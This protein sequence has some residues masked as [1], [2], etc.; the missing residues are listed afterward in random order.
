MSGIKGCPFSRIANQNRNRPDAFLW[1]KNS[2]KSSC[3]SKRHVVKLAQ[4]VKPKLLRLF[5]GEHQPFAATRSR[6]A[7]FFCTDTF[8]SNG[9]VS[10]VP[11]FTLDAH[12]TD[13]Q[14]MDFSC[15]GGVLH[16]LVKERFRGVG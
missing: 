1:I 14:P 16:W 8:C 9:R 11:R 2:L 7:E 15:F 6:G 10:R 4:V 5:W 12:S 13:S 3:A